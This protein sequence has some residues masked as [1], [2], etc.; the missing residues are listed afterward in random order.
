MAGTPVRVISGFIIDNGRA[1]RSRRATVVFIGW[2]LDAEV[3]RP[4][5]YVLRGHMS[6]N[7]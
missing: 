6:A 3:I 1:Q 5:A 4:G 7:C 2:E